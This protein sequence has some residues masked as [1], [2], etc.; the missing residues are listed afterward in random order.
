MPHT[1][2]IPEF[3]F[4]IGKGRK[5]EA[6]IILIKVFM[7]TVNWKLDVCGTFVKI[8]QFQNNDSEYKEA[9]LK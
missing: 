2:G 3:D 8:C 4:G 7:T 6:S 9:V 5:F 1:A